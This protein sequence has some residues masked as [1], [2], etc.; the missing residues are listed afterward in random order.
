MIKKDSAS[1]KIFIIVIALLL[2]ANVGTLTMLLT[3]TKSDTDDHKNGMRN[4]LKTEVGFSDAQLNAFDKIKSN[5]RAAVRVMFDEMRLRKQQNL[6]NIGSENFSDSSLIEA[7]EYAATQQQKLELKMLN[8][9]K[10]IRDLCTATQ[11]ANFDT[12]FYKIMSR[13]VP[14]TKKK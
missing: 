3:N 8:Q 10:E 5:H 11:R 1:N 13:F 7:A 14:D 6:K 4:Y 9:L 2:L 12:G